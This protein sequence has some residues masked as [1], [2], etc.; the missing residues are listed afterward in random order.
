MENTPNNINQNLIGQ[1]PAAP[2]QGKGNAVTFTVRDVF[3]MV[4][5]NWLWFALSLVISI[6]I[7]LLVFKAQPVE[8]T[9]QASILLKGSGGNKGSGQESGI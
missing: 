9:Q 6:V 2:Q 1:A 3:F 8:Y 4:I 5:N 7:S